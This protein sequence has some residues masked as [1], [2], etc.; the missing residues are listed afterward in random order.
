M[1]WHNKNAPWANV[2][3]VDG[4]VDWILITPSA[5]GSNWTFIP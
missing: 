3:F 4:H 2:L 5:S 1:R